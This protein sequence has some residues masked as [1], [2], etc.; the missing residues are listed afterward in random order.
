MNHTFETYMYLMKNN[1]IK[2]VRSYSFLIIIGL[3]IFIG[4]AC[5]PSSTAGYEVFYIGGVRG[6]Y[7]SAW[8]GGMAAML[9][10]LLLWLFGFYMLRSQISQD[11]RLK[12]GQIIAATPISNTRYISSKALSNFLVLLVIE[13][14]MILAF[15]AMQFVRGEST[16][17]QVGDYFLPFLFIAVP[18]LLVLSS[19][20]VLFDVVPGLKGVIGNMIFF[21]IW[22]F[23]SIVSIALPNSFFDVY[24]LDMIR[25]D[26]V[27]E[28]AIEYPFIAES[29]EG[30]SFGY[31]P[32]EGKI[33]TFNWQG[34]DWDSH[35]IIQRIIWLLI[36]IIIILLSSIV[37][38]RFKN[39]N[40]NNARGR[41]ILFEGKSNLVVQPEL[42]KTFR[43]SP[44]DR[45]RRLRLSRLIR[46]ELRIMLK[47]YSIWWYLLLVG[48]IVVSFLIPFDKLKSWLSVV[49]VLPIAIWSQMGT[50]EKQYFTQ[51][52]ILSSCPPLYKFFAVWISGIFITLFVSLGV[53]L[54]FLID[55]Q[56]DHFSSWTVAIFFIPTLGLFLG[57]LSGSRKMFE[58]IYMLWWYLGPVNHLPYLDF[59]G[60][61]EGYEGVYLVL[62]AALLIAAMLNQLLQTG[63]FRFERT[64][65][66]T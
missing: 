50:R 8:L 45:E 56:V 43:L 31:Y 57:V 18:S 28:A 36:A 19:L 63:S 24:G 55:G 62:V 23:F 38:N 39:Q 3:T 27:K 49:M 58:V 16:Q 41:L 5:V 6:I 64:K 37:F 14:M 13:L 29:K 10:T 15:I 25:S 52:L 66:I 21:G 53:L 20:T 2:Q 35:I 65:N 11:Q 48:T 22:I 7:N 9:S 59:L 61:S 33:A 12:V 4:Y 42:P 1:L 47:G 34:V 46:A 40:E 60:I 17:L 51:E 32:T 44:I 30:G 54:R 26:M